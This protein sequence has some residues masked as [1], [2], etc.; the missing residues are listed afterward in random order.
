MAQVII[1]SIFSFIST[2]LDDLLVV[3]FLFSQAQ[4]KRAKNGIFIGRVFGIILLLGL[5]L[6]GAYGIRFLS[7]DHV[8]YLGFF[9]ILL[10]M[11]YLY[12]ARNHEE[13][14]NEMSKTKQMK[15]QSGIS[16]IF[17]T[18]VLCFANGADNIGVYIPLFANFDL[19]QS[20]VS[21]I[22]FILMAFIWC[23][24]AERFANI[25]QMKVLINKYQ[26]ILI[27]AIYIILGVMILLK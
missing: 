24:L 19:E 26:H 8:K 27:P 4:G 9:P 16:S 6:L 21:F 3:M 2:N 5:S 1:S 13:K 14:S 18:I 22:L 10:G 20:V 7:N 15:N 25:R 23:L 11:K 12:D 17:H